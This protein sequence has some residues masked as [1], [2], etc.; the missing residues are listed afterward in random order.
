MQQWF[1]PAAERAAPSRKQRRKARQADRRRREARRL[2]IHGLLPCIHNPNTLETG[3]DDGHAPPGV[4]EQVRSLFQ[5][6]G[7]ITAVQLMSTDTGK[8]HRG[9]RSNNNA[10]GDSAGI[11]LEYRICMQQSNVS[12][13][14]A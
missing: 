14:Y 4:E 6:W 2:V 7:R 11:L 13:A 10:F 12:K 1:V 9:S 8:A 3:S 5:R